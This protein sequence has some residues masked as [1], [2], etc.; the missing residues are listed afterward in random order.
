MPNLYVGN[1]IQ[2]KALSNIDYFTQFVKAWIPFN[3][4]Y[5][6]VYPALRNDRAC[7]NE[8]KKVGSVTYNKIYDYI[9][10]N[11]A[12]SLKF[13][14]YI[15]ELHHELERKAILNR[16]ERV[17]FQNIVLGINPNKIYNETIY[18][19]KYEVEY[20]VGGGSSKNV[21]SK[22]TDKFGN[23]F[24]NFPQTDYNIEELRRY[25][26]F[27]TLPR[28]QRT[29]L[30]FGYKEIN[31]FKPEN[32]LENSP[33]DNRDGSPRNYIQMGQYKFINDESKLCQA[34][35][36]IIYNLR[37]VL[38]HGQIVPDHETVVIYEPAYHILK[39]LL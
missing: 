22:L 35:I 18:S 26:D 4:W 17:S 8:V 11:D 9:R 37:N 28:P 33:V 16:D 21:I 29:Y 23:E 20:S 5:K 19:I 36:E 1:E 24:F 6:N 2:W 39:M 27:I 32:M 15:G 13:K 34:I 38:F 30:D 12:N 10:N 31:P 25:P 14:K 3:A 7:I